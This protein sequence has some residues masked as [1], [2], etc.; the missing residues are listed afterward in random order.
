MAALFS[1]L[2]STG[3]AR[4]VGESQSVTAWLS[5]VHA[6]SY[7]IVMSAGLVW[8]LHAGG[9]LLRQASSASVARPARRL[10]VVGLAISILTGI[11]L[12]A[13]RASYTGPVGAFQLKLALIVGASILQFATTRAVLRGLPPAITTLRAAGV[14]GL[15]LWLALAATACW[16]IL[17]E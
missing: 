10:L 11:S 7:T 6:V 16:F 2:E 9:L 8:S 3:L 14:A 13:P 1:W 12:F 5:A 17:F 15:V 4:V